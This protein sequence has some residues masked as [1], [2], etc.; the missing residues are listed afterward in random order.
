MTRYSIPQRSW[1]S[2]ETSGLLEGRSDYQRVKTGASRMKGF[3]PLRQGP[4]TRAPGTTFRGYTEGNQKARPLNFEFA[5]DDA[6]VLEFTPLKMRVRRYGSLVEAG[7]GVYELAT[8]YSAEALDRLVWVQSAD[9]IYI[10]D[11]VLPIHKLSRRALDDWSIAPAAFKNGPFRAGNFDEDLTMQASGETGVITLTSSQD[12][13]EADHVGSLIRLQAVDYT[14]IPLWTGNTNIAIGDQR[15]YGENIYELEVGTN[16]GVNP[17]IHIEGSRAVDADTTWKFLSDGGG[18]AEIT[19]VTSATEASAT[20]TKRLPRGVVADPTYRF[21]ESAWSA[22]HG[23]PAVLEIFD[24]RLAAA[25]TPSDPRTIWFSAGGDFADQEPSLEPDGAF[26]YS[27]GGTRTRNRILWLQAGERGLFVG[28]LGQIFVSRRL[29]DRAIIGPTNIEFKPLG[30]TGAAPAQALAPSGNPIFISKDGKRLF[31]LGYNFQADGIKPRELSLPADH[32]GEEGFVEL[33]W[34]SAPLGTVWVRRGNGEMAAVSYDPDEEVLGWAPYSVAGGVIEAAVVTPSSDASR[35]VLTLYVARQI[36]GVTVRMVEEQDL[37]WGIG[38]GGQ[39]AA[40]AQHLF[41]ASVFAQEPET[42][43]FSVPHLA[44]QTVVAWT[45]KG[46]FGPYDVPPNGE[47]TLA[48][49]VGRAVI[50]LF[51]ETHRL[52]SSPHEPPAADGVTT[53]RNRRICSGTGVRVRRSCLGR[54]RT[55]ERTADGERLGELQDLIPR[56][57]GQADARDVSASLSLS[58]TSGHAPDVMIEYLPVGGAPLTI[59]HHVVPVEESGT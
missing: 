32:L 27:I 9:V 36:N 51:D 37:P 25:A 42:D 30:D 55:V 3:L 23:Y 34:Q 33:F 24:E 58:I 44:G 46:H 59:L 28:A 16:T 26:A 13:F 20:V 11:G 45:D 18:I 2:G 49:T 31:E 39:T 35:D 4:A 14:D 8:P 38:H 57:L 1:S 17:P 52:R 47:I 29:D 6:L 43:T 21:Q 12:Y 48:D 54:A 56:T 22:R 10:C 41:A 15:R 50:G 7:G 40:E 53:G 5:E 19:A